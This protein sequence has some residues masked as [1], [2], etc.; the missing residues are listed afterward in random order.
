M[1]V[2]VCVIVASRLAVVRLKNTS[3]AVCLDC[4][5]IPR[6]T[7]MVFINKPLR[8]ADADSCARIDELR[9]RRKPLAERLCY[10]RSASKHHA[11]TASEAEQIAQ[12]VAELNREITVWHAKAKATAAEAQ[13]KQLRAA[14][15]AITVAKGGADK[16]LSDM[17]K[18]A[19]RHSNTMMALVAKQAE[20]LEGVDEVAKVMEAA[21]VAGEA[22]IGP[23]A[24]G[25]QIGADGDD[26]TIAIADRDDQP[27]VAVVKGAAENLADGD[28]A[29]KAEPEAAVT[30]AGMSANVA[31]PKYAK[32]CRDVKRLATHQR[33]CKVPIDVEQLLGAHAPA[34]DNPAAAG[35]EQAPDEVIIPHVCGYCTRTFLAANTLD[36]HQRLCKAGASKGRSTNDNVDSMFTCLVCS[37]EYTTEYSLRSHKRHCREPSNIKPGPTTPVAPSMPA[38]PVTPAAPVDPMADKICPACCKMCRGTRGLASHR[39]TCQGQPDAA[40][41]PVVAGATGDVEQAQDAEASNSVSPAVVDKEQAPDGEIDSRIPGSNHLKMFRGERALK[42]HDRHKK[43]SADQEEAPADPLADQICQACSKVC[44]GMRGLRLHRRACRERTDTVE[45]AGPN[46]AGAAADGDTEVTLAESKRRR[47]SKTKEHPEVNAPHDQPFGYGPAPNQLPVD[48]ALLHSTMQLVLAKQE[49]SDLTAMSIEDDRAC[50]VAL[51]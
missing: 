17:V 34:E 28:G 42:T 49:K 14:S 3:A 26:Q 29:Q 18:E 11:A 12:K 27:C 8:E 15:A 10:L 23:A 30:S 5:R 47:R 24:D 41:C 7:A 1:W 43:R 40:N 38:A 2:R 51:V 16:V 21:A 9:L 25:E 46:V 35:T 4:A 31:C 50:E 6:Q 13:C 20:H 39:R 48:Q 36:R 45:A 32:I 19:Q 33:R 37:K 44:K 22:A